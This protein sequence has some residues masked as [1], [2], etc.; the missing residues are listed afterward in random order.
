MSRKALQIGKD[1]GSARA[2]MGWVDRERTLMVSHARRPPQCWQPC[3]W[4]REPCP[5][6]CR[7]VTAVPTAV[8]P[9]IALHMPAFLQRSQAELEASKAAEAAWVAKHEALQRRIASLEVGGAC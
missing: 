7:L 1:V 8:M 4:L 3:T 2:S 9:S 6:L 5:S